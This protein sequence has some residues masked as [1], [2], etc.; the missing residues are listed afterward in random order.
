MFSL[1]SL[2]DSPT[3]YVQTPVPPTCCKLLAATAY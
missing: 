1:K 2:H 3:Q